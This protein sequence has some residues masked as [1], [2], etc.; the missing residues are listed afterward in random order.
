MNIKELAAKWREKLRQAGVLDND[1]ISVPGDGVLN[2]LSE[3]ERATPEA[4]PEAQEAA[5]RLA[6]WVRDF[7]AEKQ[8]AFI[9]DVN[10]LIDNVFP[11][12]SDESRQPSQPR[13]EGSGE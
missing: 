8:P 2:M 7:G 3:F 6:A 4:S 9:R 5:I 1:M 10:L 12:R 11:N 13:N